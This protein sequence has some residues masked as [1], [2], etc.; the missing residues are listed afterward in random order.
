MSDDPTDLP[1]RLHDTSEIGEVT[2]RMSESNEATALTE[3]IVRVDGDQAETIA[4]AERL[5]ALHGLPLVRAGLHSPPITPTETPSPVGCLVYC[6]AT[7][8]VA[9][10]DPGPAPA[11]PVYHR[12][13][14]IVVAD[15]KDASDVACAFR[16]GLFD[17][18]PA[19]V[20][21]E[22]LV[23][24]VRD[25]LSAFNQAHAKARERA[26]VMKRFQRLTAR[27]RRVTEMV[28]QGMTNKS[29]AARTGVTVKAIEAHRARVMRK[30]QCNS[31]AML[32]RMHVALESAG[33]AGSA[34]QNCF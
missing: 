32:V 18:L 10:A 24:R 6:G 28:V 8:F 23:A 30:L 19:E 22:R 9:L 17:W 26:D 16:E 13:N 27:E 33:A 11:S 7:P 31:L 5:L 4:R 2:R 3:G 20:D 14:V 1:P 12:P 29:I 25:A 21:G 34:T 15:A